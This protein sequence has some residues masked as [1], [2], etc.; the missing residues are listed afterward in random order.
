MIR[1]ANYLIKQLRV[2]ARFPSRDHRPLTLGQ[3]LSP[4]VS[5]LFISTSAPDSIAMST[6]TQEDLFSS[7]QP[8][9]VVSNILPSVSSLPEI[10]IFSSGP[11][12]STFDQPLASPVI[13]CAVGPVPNMSST[14][15]SEV[16]HFR[17]KLCFHVVSRSASPWRHR[18]RNHVILAP[19]LC[20][21][22]TVTPRKQWLPCL[23]HSVYFVC[24]TTVFVSSLLLFAAT[25][26]FGPRPAPSCSHTSFCKFSQATFHRIPVFFSRY[27]L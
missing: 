7:T 23:V 27:H 5:V 24:F 3:V 25:F 20:A 26:I 18:R 10:L 16:P 22:R 19:M 14:A 8:Q 15:T 21:D 9:T 11:S 6:A 12:L 4:I 13:C 17:A 2:T 1:S